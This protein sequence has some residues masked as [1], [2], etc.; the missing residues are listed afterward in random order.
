MQSLERSLELLN[1]EVRV[2]LHVSAQL[3]EEISL[4]MRVAVPER[5]LPLTIGREE[6]ERTSY[7]VELMSVASL[8]N[9]MSDETLGLKTYGAGK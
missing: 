6:A 4:D 9:P 5:V 8:P 1:V 7:L 3:E 2:T